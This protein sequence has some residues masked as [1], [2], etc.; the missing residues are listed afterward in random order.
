MEEDGLL[1]LLIG[2]YLSR[3]VL[4]VRLLLVKLVKLELD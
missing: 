4:D 2:V 1:D 3:A